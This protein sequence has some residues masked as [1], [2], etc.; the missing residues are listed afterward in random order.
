MVGIVN[1][2][3]HVFPIVGCDIEDIPI[4]PVVTGWTRR[5][6]PGTFGIVFELELRIF[7]GSHHGEGMDDSTFRAFQ[8]PLDRRDE[9]H[10]DIA[11]DAK[12]FQDLTQS[13]L[14][15]EFVFKDLPVTRNILIFEF[16]FVCGIIKFKI[17]EEITNHPLDRLL[18][19]GI[20]LPE[21]QGEV[22]H[23]LDGQRSGCIPTGAPRRIALG[24][25]FFGRIVEVV[26]PRL[27]TNSPIF[28][29]RK[30]A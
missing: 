5:F 19:S 29:I 11:V 30:N 8:S 27:G 12:T 28:M 21:K 13:E 20:M 22:E 2:Q 16:R 3:T 14:D 9:G 1:G 6:E 18:K 4:A 17:G 26:S 15:V 23:L 10:N 7:F 25:D 24:K